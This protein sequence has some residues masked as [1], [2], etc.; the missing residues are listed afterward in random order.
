M[1]VRR[2]RVE[3]GWRAGGGRQ[4]GF[5]NVGGSEEL[6]HAGFVRGVKSRRVVGTCWRRRR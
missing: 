4:G 3:R 6:S 1:R 2:V 5:R